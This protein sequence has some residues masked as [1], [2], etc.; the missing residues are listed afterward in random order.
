MSREGDSS[1]EESEIDFGRSEREETQW[2]ANLNNPTPIGDVMKEKS[3][4]I[5]YEVLS[6]PAPKNKRQVRWHWGEDLVCGAGVQRGRH[7]TT[8][9]LEKGKDFFELTTPRALPA[10]SDACNLVD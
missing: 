10:S 9:A 6:Q 4:R 3:L 5:E 8:P 7:T 2:L 1:S